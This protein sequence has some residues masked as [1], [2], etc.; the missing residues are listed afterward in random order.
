MDV[1]V[2]QLI[3]D[4]GIQGLGESISEGAGERRRGGLQAQLHGAL[5]GCGDGQ[6]QGAAGVEPSNQQHR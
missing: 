2:V 6:D 3:G 1:V 5:G 4:G